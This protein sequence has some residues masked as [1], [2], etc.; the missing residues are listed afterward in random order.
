MSIL[1]PGPEGLCLKPSHLML[2][3]CDDTVSVSLWEPLLHAEHGVHDRAAYGASG[4]S[5]GR[6]GHLG[7]NVPSLHLQALLKG[8]NLSSMAQGPV[9]VGGCV[10]PLIFPGTKSPS[11]ASSLI[12]VPWMS[13]E[14]IWG[15]PP[16]LSACASHEGGSQ[17]FHSSSSSGHTVGW[18]LHHP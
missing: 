7:I 8:K 2:H 13:K 16:Q 11:L 6:A 14:S 1:T 4:G 9:P 15:I 18:P 10:A 5:R 3:S 12:Q 17:R